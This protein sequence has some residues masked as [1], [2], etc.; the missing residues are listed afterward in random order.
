MGASR[1]T[2]RR[3]AHLD[4]S[5]RLL[6][7]MKRRRLRLRH[8]RTCSTETRTTR[9]RVRSFSTGRESD[10]ISLLFGC[11]SIYAQLGMATQ[12]RSG[13]P[14]QRSDY[15]TRASALYDISHISHLFTTSR[16]KGFLLPLASAY[17]TIFYD[18][19]LV[20]D[21]ASEWA[22]LETVLNPHTYCLVTFLYRL[23]Y[24]WLEGCS[25]SMAARR[26][27][28]R[29]LERGPRPGCFGNEAGVERINLRRSLSA[30]V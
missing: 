2:R 13:M 10:R 29:I 1:S 11:S 19:F 15:S 3:A 20:I 14:V 25:G 26:A 6:L 21:G 28:T 9:I 22:E 30:C 24:P 23:G 18:I 27:S 17:T 7:W 16:T 12:R 8:V 5:R 4:G